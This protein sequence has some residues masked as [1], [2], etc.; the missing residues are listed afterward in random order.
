[1]LDFIK[2]L[3]INQ[4][5]SALAGSKRFWLAASVGI[6]LFLSLVVPPLIGLASGEFNLNLVSPSYPLSVYEVRSREGALEDVFNSPIRGAS[7]IAISHHHGGLE[8][9]RSYIE[10]E[11]SLRLGD[12]IIPVMKNDYSG[13][14]SYYW[15]RLFALFI[16]D[17]TFAVHL[18][19]ILLG[20]LTI[21]LV[22]FIALLFF[23][24]KV[25]AAGALLLSTNP[26]FIFW[27]RLPAFPEHFNEVFALAIILLFIRM[28]QSRDARCF[29]LCAFLTGFGLYQKL[30]LVWILLPLLSIFICFRYRFHLTIKQWALGAI[31]ALLGLTPLILF[32]LDFSETAN[33][34]VDFFSSEAFWSGI[35]QR[36]MARA[37]QCYL[38]FGDPVGFFHLLV[39]GAGKSHMSIF[40]ILL[41]ALSFG[42]PVINALRKTPWLDRRRAAFMPVMVVLMFVM[43]SVMSK[44][45]FDFGHT[46]MFI[47]FVVLAPAVFITHLP[48]LGQRRFGGASP[49]SLLLL[50]AA[51]LIQ[52][53]QLRSYYSWETDP[54]GTI[55]AMV[56]THL[57]LA[58]FLSKKK[59]TRPITTSYNLMGILEFISKEK[60]MPLH[61]WTYWKEGEHKEETLGRILRKNRGRHYI[62]KSGFRADVMNLH[63]EPEVPF[64]FKVAQKNNITL[65][66][67]KEFKTSNKIVMYTLYKLN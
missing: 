40:F 49:I 23:N 38:V 53:G 1:M 60:I 56:D 45:G 18:S 10:P 13:A 15:A 47:P 54:K 26:A 4:K 29:Y 21:L 17:R 36:A 39:F 52:V 8:T 50:C 35:L 64:L 46:L 19:S 67:I 65:E 24:L 3:S 58:G 5:L 48:A 63:P 57:S 43:T 42:F 61:Y 2:E 41:L 32:N 28:L 14:I 6:Y 33:A 12:T 62:I 30:T 7:T 11:Y 31:L 66:R 27:R 9:I 44:G 34:S 51:L 20:A 22:F 37:H 59:I 25:A 16:T 55:R